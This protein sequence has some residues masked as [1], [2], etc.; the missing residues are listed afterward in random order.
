MPSQCMAGSEPSHTDI[1]VTSRVG[2]R[3][4]LS[5]AYGSLLCWAW[6]CVSRRSSW[7]NPNTIGKRKHF[8]ACRG[9]GNAPLCSSI[10][11][12]S[13]LYLTLQNAFAC[14]QSDICMLSS[15][16]L[17]GKNAAIRNWHS[18]MH[19]SIAY[20][21][22]PKLNTYIVCSE[23]CLKRNTGSSVTIFWTLLLVHVLHSRTWLSLLVD[24]FLRGSSLQSLH[25]TYQGSFG[26]FL[27]LC[28]SLL[29]SLHFISMPTFDNLFPF[30]GS[31]GSLCP[32]IGN[33]QCSYILL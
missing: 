1:Q 31:D 33:I 16:G 20:A 23:Y 9:S 13:T 15:W 6:M 3:P 5:H 14:T 2:L 32:S 17:R 29:Q 10:Q 28:F 26:H 4:K 30:L 7:T 25:L 24:P 27:A 12:K 18:V 22:L 19:A 21:N 11:K 8:S